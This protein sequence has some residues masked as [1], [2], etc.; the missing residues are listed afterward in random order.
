M[1]AAVWVPAA[2]GA[3]ASIGGAVIQS[4]SAG[5][6]AD[7]QAA[8]GTQAAGTLGQIYQQQRADMAPYAGL[9]AQAVGSLGS[10][11]GFPKLP[12]GTGSTMGLPP[13]APGVPAPNT[14]GAVDTQPTMGGF[15]SGI[16]TGEFAVPRKG[17][18]GSLA[19]Q[20]R[21]ASGYS[22]QPASGGMVQLQAPTGEVQSVPADQAGHYIAQGAR[23]VN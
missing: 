8:S 7:I 13:M 9:G 14:P 12:A 3:A 17:T 2:I 21:T 18:L 20:Q 6:A 5:K 10:L 4:K 23:R 16:A 22:A 11:A 19:S 15:R 1:P